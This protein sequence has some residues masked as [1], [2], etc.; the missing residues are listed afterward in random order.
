[1]HPEHEAAT[2]MFARYCKWIGDTLRS[3]ARLRSSG[4]PVTGL[5]GGTIRA[6]A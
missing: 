6:G 5:S 2:P 1:M 3:T 4:A